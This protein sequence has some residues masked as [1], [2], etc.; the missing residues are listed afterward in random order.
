MTLP[1]RERPAG[2]LARHF[3]HAL[4]DFGVFTQAGTDSFVRLLI[5]LFSML[6]AFGFLLV[7]MYAGKY[8]GLSGAPTGEPYAHALLADTAVV[9][10]LPMWIVAL[11]T[12]L[13]SQSLF[14]DETDFRVL[15]PLPIGRSRSRTIRPAVRRRES[16]VR[17]AGSPLAR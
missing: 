4:F 5:G 7:R 3:F 1:L 10:A 6:F 12:V 11:V 14:P 2:L 16:G 15:M 17:S 9:I 13:I 8:A